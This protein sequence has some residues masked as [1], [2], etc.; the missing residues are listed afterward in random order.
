MPFTTNCGTID[1]NETLSNDPYIVITSTSS[2]EADYSKITVSLDT[3]G[4]IFSFNDPTE[5][6]W[7]TEKNYSVEVRATTGS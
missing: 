7:Y 6:Y 3:T 1:W 2:P 5:E 4:I